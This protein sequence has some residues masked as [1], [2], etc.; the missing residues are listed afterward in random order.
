[1]NREIPIFREV[2]KFRQ[3]WLWVIVLGTA[4]MLWY[5]MIQQIIYKIPFGS[6][7]APDWWLV[8]FWILFGIGLPALFFN[9]QLIT[10]VRT[11]GVYVRFV[12]IHRS[13]VRILKE[14]IVKFRKVEYSPVWQYGGWGIRYGFGGKA[15]NV[16]GNQ[17]VS[18]EL[19][20][21]RNLLIGSQKAED[22]YNALN[23]VVK[24]G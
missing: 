16:S 12:P 13:S 22:L 20:N 5:G 19:K 23:Q 3:Y 15:Y 24:K 18:L 9:M 11:D 17:G 14:D 10:E 1:M 2:Q 7:P 8:L 21:G 6:N 4:G